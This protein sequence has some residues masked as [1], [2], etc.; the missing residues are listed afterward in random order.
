MKKKLVIALIAVFLL[1][2]TGV[3]FAQVICPPCGGSGE[4]TCTTCGGSGYRDHPNDSRFEI[5]CTNCGG[6]GTRHKTNPTG[7]Q[8]FRAG[9]GIVQ[10]GACGGKGTQPSSGG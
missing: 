1:A 4:R 7:N 2:I 8:G 5:G 10:C 3:V 6:S 9:R